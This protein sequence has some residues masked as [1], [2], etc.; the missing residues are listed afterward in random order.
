MAEIVNQLLGGSLGYFWPVYRGK[1]PDLDDALALRGFLRERQAELELVLLREDPFGS[2]QTPAPIGFVGATEHSGVVI[3]DLLTQGGTMRAGGGRVSTDRYTAETVVAEPEI[4]SVRN[5]NFA[6]VSALFH[7]ETA[8]R[9]SGLRAIEDKVI[10]NR[11]GRVQRIHLD[12]RSVPDLVTQLGPSTELRLS[13][14]WRKSPDPSRGYVI[15]A[16]LKALVGTTRP[17]ASQQIGAVLMRIQDL[18]SV[19][20]RG[21][22]EVVEGTARTV[23]TNEASSMWNAQLMSAPPAQVT[24]AERSGLP[25]FTLVQVGGVEGVAR[26]IRLCARHPRAVGP[27]VNRLRRGVATPEVETLELAASIE[28]WVAANRRLGRVWAQKT[29]RQD[30][31]AA[32]LTRYVGPSFAQWLPGSTNS[33][34]NAFWGHYNGIKHDPRFN[35]SRR[36]LWLLSEGARLLLTGSLLNRVSLTRRPAEAIFSHHFASRLGQ[37]LRK[38]V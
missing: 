23:G 20:F 15:D 26:W 18:L 3:R 13:A 38:V 9:W 35:Y 31:P 1:S 22:Y 27:I 21:H 2:D 30:T 16:G 14:Y 7:G 17:R 36:D 37:E 11:Q 6:S 32:A 4:E 25:L 28:Y 10:T 29:S 5:L 19:A 24:R 34:A 12:M 33:W 8:L